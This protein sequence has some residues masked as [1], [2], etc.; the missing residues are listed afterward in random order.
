MQEQK[1]LNAI[2]LHYFV[3]LHIILTFVVRNKASA[4]MAKLRIK[5]LLQEANMTQVELA[6]AVGIARPNMSNIVTGKT[7]PSLG[8]LESIADALGVEVAE[9]FRPQDDFL[10]IIRENGRTLTFL[11]RDALKEYMTEWDSLQ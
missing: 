9:L 4:I 6:E 3:M 11:K 2:F 7:N 5:E 8:T 1:C 10:A